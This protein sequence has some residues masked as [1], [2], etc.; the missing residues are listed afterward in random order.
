MRKWLNLIFCSLPVILSGEVEDSYVSNEVFVRFKDG[1]GADGIQELIVQKQLTEKRRFLLTKAILY[2]LPE[3]VDA[4]DAKLALGALPGVLYADLNHKA[5]SPAG[6]ISNE[7]YLG[8]QWSLSNS[9]QTVNNISGSAGNDI[10]WLE[11]M[12]SY[13]SIDDGVVVA[14]IDSGLALDHP[15]LGTRIAGMVD[16]LNGF[17]NHDDDG[18]GFIDDLVGWDFIDNDNDPSDLMGH[19]TNVAG[20]IAG[21]PDN[22]MGI[23]GVAP[24]AYILPLRVF[25]EYG[26]GATDERI[27]SAMEYAILAGARIIN[28]S[29]GAGQPFSIPIQDA[30]IS[31]ETEFDTLLICAA[32]NGG[33]DGFGDDLDVAPFYPACYDGRVILSV[34]ATDQRNQLARFSN[35]GAVKVDLAAPGTNI[36]VPDI[37]RG[38][39]FSEDF[40]TYNEEWLSYDWRYFTDATGN[41]WV[42]DSV[43]V[44]QQPLSYPPNTNSILQSPLYNLQGVNAPQMT[45]DVYHELAY[46]YATGSYDYLIF[47]ITADGGSTWDMLGYVYG[48]SEAGVTSYTYDLSDYE[49]ESVNIRFRLYSDHSLEADG[50]YVD[51]LSISGVTAFSYTGEEYSFVNG[52]SFAAPIV[53]GVA[54]LILAQRPDLS[55]LDA[56]DIL[57]QSVTKVSGLDGKMVSGGVVNA[58]EAL[59][60]A[61]AW[62][63]ASLPDTAATYIRGDATDLGVLNWK[64]SSWFGL[65]RDFGSGWIY[66]SSLSW[67]YLVDSG[68]DGTWIYHQDLKWMWT[69]KE[70]YPWVY[71]HEL[72]GWRYF[73]GSNGFYD[74][75]AGTWYSLDKLVVQMSDSTAPSLALLG[76]SSIS[77]TIG[78]TYAEAGATATDEIDGDLTDS[79]VIGGDSVDVNTAGTYTI[80][81]D[82]SDS[83]GNAASQVA[84]TVTV[85]A[86]TSNFKIILDYRYDNGYFSEN[87][88]RK[89]ALEYAAGLWESIIQSSH[90][91][92]SGTSIKLRSSWTQPEYE[93]LNFAD[94]MD[95]FLVFV[96]AYDSQQEVDGSGDPSPGTFKAVGSSFSTPNLGALYLNTN[97]DQSSE[98]F[99]D[100]TPETANDIPS[101]THYDFVETAIHEFGHILGILR[102]TQAPFI[103]VGD[104]GQDYFDGPAVRSVNGNQPL[105]LAKDSSHIDS[106]F[107]SGTFLPMPNMDRLSMHAS[108]VIQGFRSLMTP[109]DVAMLDDMGYD[110]NYDFIPKSVYGDPSLVKQ[111][112][113]SYKSQFIPGGSSTSPNGLWL[114]DYVYDTDKSITGYPLRYMPPAGGV[115][116]TADLFSED[117]ITIPKDGYLIVN[118]SLSAANSPGDDVTVYSLLMDVRVNSISDW[119][120][121]FNTSF[122]AYHDGELFIKGGAKIGMS[123]TYSEDVITL[124]QWHRVVFTYNANTSTAKVYVDGALAVTNTNISQST[125]GLYSNESG[126]PLLLLFGDN[127]GDSD[128]IDLKAAALYGEELSGS[129][130][131]QLGNTTIRTFAF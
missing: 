93:I 1:A 31:L 48:W 21:T 12:E 35:Y 94:G 29:L 6:Y 59:R 10:S 38:I 126:T 107:T 45:V 17:D 13:T 66:H 122:G 77:L 100:T 20:V 85:T 27:V 78:G 49:W 118:H 91:V 92:A 124:D 116:I 26:G 129:Q 110:I 55:A 15:E 34:A 75:E 69:Q 39:V 22:G 82:V 71:C 79:I 54:A 52:T 97:A 8:S 112:Q 80:T 14:V 56:R 7:P 70:I 44:N 4:A 109:L 114:F 81:Y 87:P 104:D 60:I 96:Y 25:D 103:V 101:K 84:R 5:N 98:W 72:R 18:L 24:D 2:V 108:N 113:D 86:S 127:D 67:L 120:S 63:Y 19:G 40:E 64:V 51:N 125:Y 30:I 105:P 117:H 73:G 57:M 65:Y 89:I 123:V 99:F 58:A 128:V 32:G 9:G 130:V 53:S 36:L 46:D 47:E 121:L 50:V 119:R 28:L 131:Q 68:I 43:D 3:G 61:N 106:S 16:E 111:Y 102:G 42:V 95:G 76:E 74:P 115:G 37:S 62:P 33:D 41:T 83:R 90:T 88:D 11:A 23:T